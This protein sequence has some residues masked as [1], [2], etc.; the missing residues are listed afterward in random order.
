M[1]LF[2]PSLITLTIACISV[3]IDVNAGVNGC[4]CSYQSC[5][6]HLSYHPRDHYHVPVHLRCRNAGRSR[7]GLRAGW[8]NL[9]S[10]A[11]TDVAAD[12]AYPRT[13]SSLDLHSPFLFFLEIIN[14]RLKKSIDYTVKEK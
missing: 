10:L 8:G 2:I 14:Y 13:G 3:C 9:A 1:S 4:K 12:V 5:A 7:V 6:Y 11:A